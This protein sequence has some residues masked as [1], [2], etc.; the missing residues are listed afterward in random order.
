MFELRR[1]FICIIKLNSKIH[2]MYLDFEKLE[3]FY[4]PVRI[5]EKVQITCDSA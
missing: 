3:L 4:F 5:R 2:P 1:D